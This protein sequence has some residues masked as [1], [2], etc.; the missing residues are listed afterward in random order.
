MA[1][2]AL[3]GIF[4]CVCATLAAFGALLGWGEA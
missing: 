1:I 2:E 4:G 3:V